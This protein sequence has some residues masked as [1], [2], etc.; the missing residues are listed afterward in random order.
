MA[1]NAFLNLLLFTVVIGHCGC[2]SSP[3]ETPV[4]PNHSSDKLP[5]PSESR[6]DIVTN[7][8]EP[9]GN[10]V[11]PIRFTDVTPESGID[12]TYYGVPSD[13]AYMTEQNGGG[14][15]IFDADGD[16]IS[17]LFLA[18]GSH[19]QRPAKTLEHSDQLY[20]GN[21]DCSFRNTTEQAFVRQHSFGMGVASGDFNNDGFTDLF[22]ACFGKNYLLQNLG[23]GTFQS[24]LIEAADAH[25]V[26]SCSPAFADFNGDGL[27]DLF[28]V[29]YVDWTAN[30]PPCSVPEHPEIRRT[31]SP[32]SKN[33]IADQLFL[34]NGDN[35]F[36]EIGSV[37]GIAND[38][39]GKGLAIGV[40]DV[41]NDGALDIYVA[42]DTTANSLFINQPGLK[43]TDAAVQYGVAVSVDG[44]HGA[45]M[46][47][48]IADF[49]HD[50]NEDV[51]V[52]NFRN[53]VND[54]YE[55]LGDA[56]FAFANTET[57]LDLSSR[58][59]LAFGAVFRDFNGDSWPDI[60]ISNGHIWDLTS[61]GKQ[62]EYRMTAS[63]LANQS[64]T[65]FR[66]VSKH[67]GGYFQRKW[68]GRSVATGDLDNDGDP[69][70]V[71]QHL[72]SPAA[73]LRNDSI[74][75]PQ[76]VVIDFVGVVS[77]RT[78][79]GCRVRHSYGD[80]L[81]VTHL[82][83]GESFQASHDRRITVPI[84]QGRVLELLEITWPNGRIEQWHDINTT[85]GQR[86]V[87]VEGG[88][89]SVQPSR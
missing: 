26:W 7:D 81:L 65:R 74:S 42:N 22:V 68:L 5:V 35:T 6:T 1:R 58:S 23:D 48:G 75:S 56:G 61:L 52:T 60:F 37:A 4:A 67:A 31:C 57:G 8:D 86:L 72:E 18:N 3:S 51:L 16:Q 12:F 82:P 2:G 27:L 19:F 62:Y 69:D 84:E 59:K 15:A 25:D 73:I 88:Q 78:P 43:F 41:N 10:N 89:I 55:S 13:E 20:L 63:L 70:L 79:L 45:S 44:V 21:S 38:D 36:E 9:T 77:T 80:D 14:I 39:I 30:D 33:A 71:V 85:A 34:N 40:F 17:D 47:V 53:Q 50:G 66:E 32:T 76:S 64:G 29:N 49:N 11:L 87:A 83:S 24:V 28:V 54:L 46:G